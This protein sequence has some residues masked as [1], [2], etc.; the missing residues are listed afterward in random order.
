[1]TIRDMQ[2]FLEVSKTCNMTAAGKNLYIS[3]STVS[4]TILS[5]E[6]QYEVRL[7]DRMTGRLIITK[8][9]AVLLEYCKKIL[10]LHKRMEY[11]LRYASEKYIRI[12]TTLISLSSILINNIWVSYH[13]ACPNVKTQICV[14][15][16]DVLLFKLQN[17][18][19]DIVIIEE[20]LQHPDLVCHK[21]AEDSFVL[22][23][24]RDS[25]FFNRT[26]IRMEELQDC[27]LIMRE[28]GNPTRDLFEQFL[29]DR[30]LRFNIINYSNI[31]IIKAEVSAG[32]GVSIMARHLFT[33]ELQQGL[34]HGIPILDFPLK[35]YFYTVHHK[36]LHMTPYIKGF[37]QVCQAVT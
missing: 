12:G 23:C 20:P 30:N 16:S 14:D 2:I 24:G 10:E 6:R 29:L 26:S 3:Q 17:S 28:K 33:T 19:V 34:L 4:Q 15:E 32:K 1:M 36:N 9:G 37:L 25:E 5:I 21:I 7:F 18:E 8:Q 13:R 27:Q 11:E 31:D 35:R 22:I